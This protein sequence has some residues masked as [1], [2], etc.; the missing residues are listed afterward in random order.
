LPGGYTVIT[1]GGGGEGS[2]PDGTL[3]LRLHSCLECDNIEQGS[4]SGLNYAPLSPRQG[5]FI[6]R[7]IDDG[8]PRTGDVRAK[9]FGNGSAVD[10]CEPR[11]NEIVEKPFCI[12]A[13]VLNRN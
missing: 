5:G 13:F 12:M 4:N 6:D 7:K 3:V 10:D 1:A 9:A 8:L 2:F 11:Y